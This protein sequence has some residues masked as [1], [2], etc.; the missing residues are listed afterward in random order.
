MFWVCWFVWD[1]IFH[2]L[3]A[4]NALDRIKEGS[5]VNHKDKCRVLMHIYRIKKDGTEEFIC[6][7]AV[8]KQI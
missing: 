5:E 6:R 2:S 8:E 7:A 4:K 3:N 1:H